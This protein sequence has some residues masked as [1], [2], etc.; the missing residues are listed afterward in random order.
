MAAGPL[1]C[2]LYENGIGKTNIHIQQGKFM[3]KPS[4]SL[5]K[6]RIDTESGKIM[7]LFAGGNAYISNEILVEI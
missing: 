3:N 4:T 6:V 5:I 2:Y 7:N 1:G